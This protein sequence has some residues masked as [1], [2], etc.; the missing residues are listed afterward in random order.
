MIR[1]L[2]QEILESD[3][4]QIIYKPGPEEAL[5][6]LESRAEPVALLICGWDSEGSEVNGLIRQAETVSPMTQRMLVVPEEEN[7]SLIQ[8]INTAHIHA[9]LSYPFEAEDFITQTTICRQRF[10]EWEQHERYKRLIER[11][12]EQMYDLAQRLKKKNQSGQDQIREKKTL[13]SQLEKQKRELEKAQLVNETLELPRIMEFLGQP[14]TQESVSTLFSVAGHT[15]VLCLQEL[16]QN[17]KLEWAPP[18]ISPDTLAGIDL[19][20]MDESDEEIPLLDQ[21]RQAVYLGLITGDFEISVH[22]DLLPP[23]EPTEDDLLNPSTYLSLIPSEDGIQA[24]LY[25]VITLEPRVITPAAILEFARQQ[26]ITHGVIPEDQIQIWIDSCPGQDEP[27]LLAQGDAPVPSQDGSVEYFFETQYTNPGKILENGSIDFRDRGNAPF[28]DADAMLAQKTPPQNGVPGK[29]IYGQTVLVDDPYDPPFEAGDG[30]Y[31]QNEDLEIMASVNGQPHL[32]AMGKFTVNEE[33]II[34]GDVDFKTGNVDFSGNIVVR[35]TVKEGF[36]VKGVSLTAQAVEGATI[37]LT[38]DLAVSDGMTNT[39]VKTVGNVHTKFIN[40]CRILGFGNLM[41][42][43]EVVDSNIMISGKCQMPTGHI[44]ASTISATGGVEAKAIGT[45]TSAP[46]FLKVGVAEHVEEL[47][48]ANADAVDVSLK[49]IQGIKKQI[50]ELEIQGH[51]LH[52]SV[53]ETTQARDRAK[54]TISDEAKRI[55]VFKEEGEQQK[56][57]TLVRTIKNL[58]NRVEGANQE[59][60][61]LMG[62]QKQISTEIDL[63]QAQIKAQEEENLKLFKQKRQMDDYI[64]LNKPEPK[65]AVQSKI[66]QGTR[67]LAPNTSLLLKENQSRCIIQEVEKQENNLYFQEMVISPMR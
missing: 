4:W 50:S 38:G 15:L 26:G 40:N 23:L 10:E 44:I 19:V 1:N 13:L 49:K 42:F 59:I 25:P 3:G 64:R 17:L 41:A 67:I 45:E 51:E 43:K 29:D 62:E 27:L 48:R 65:V 35:G 55:E 6:L 37:E 63:L 66:L 30:T 5:N 61:R 11:Q 33:M 20:A 31:L 32:D 34:N 2:I 39:V 58:Q 52:K 54:K 36:S 7:Q 18:Q 56:A 8:A 16:A 22:D 9:C 21:L 12:N 28:V 46:P 57:M 47:K 24:K 60:D 14:V 53:T